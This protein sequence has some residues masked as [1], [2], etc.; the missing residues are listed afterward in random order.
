[1]RRRNFLKGVLLS[2][3]LGLFKSRKS[4]MSDDPFFQ[5]RLGIPFT[6]TTGTSSNNS[7][8]LIYY[9][10]EDGEL[11]NIYKYEAEKMISI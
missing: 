6:E 4:K 8:V 7:G 11:R 1:M 10:G 3:L 2:P 9:Y 5:R